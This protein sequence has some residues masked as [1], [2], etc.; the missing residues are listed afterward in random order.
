MRTW[1]VALA[2]LAPLRMV[3]LQVYMPLSSNVMF[4]MVRTALFTPPLGAKEILSV[5]AS[6]VELPTNLKFINFGNV[7][8]LK[9]AYQMSK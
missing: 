5:L 7:V 2:S 3:A 6:M 1:V 4:S 9:A 8:N